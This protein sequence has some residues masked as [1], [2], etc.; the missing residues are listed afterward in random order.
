M[1]QR[2]S[3]NASVGY[4]VPSSGIHLFPRTLVGPGVSYT[5]KYKGSLTRKAL[6]QIPW[7]L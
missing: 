2:L 1:W 4:G 6:T 7:E 3:L 5:N